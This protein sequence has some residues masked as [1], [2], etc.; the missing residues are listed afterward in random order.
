MEKPDHELPVA[1]GAVIVATKP[2]EIKTV[3]VKFGK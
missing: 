2:Y 1:A 3:K